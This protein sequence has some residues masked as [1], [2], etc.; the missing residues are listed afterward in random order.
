MEGD[1]L[2]QPIALAA[3]IRG[4]VGESMEY[5]RSAYMCAL[6]HDEV[7][8]MLAQWPQQAVKAAE[9][10][11]RSQEIWAFAA[12]VLAARDVEVTSTQI[13]FRVHD[14]NE[15]RD[16]FTGILPEWTGVRLTRSE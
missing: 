4:F 10:H 6:V 16:Y 15:T 9:A 2:P 5:G 3:E 14:F 13:D 12:E 8:E 7:D 1:P 11:G